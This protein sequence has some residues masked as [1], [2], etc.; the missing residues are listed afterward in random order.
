MR[1]GEPERK[2]NEG[3][4]CAPARRAFVSGAYFGIPS[5]VCHA[6]ASA[7]QPYIY[8]LTGSPRSAEDVVAGSIAV[9]GGSYFFP[10]LIIA[11]VKYRGRATRLAVSGSMQFFVDYPW[12]GVAWNL[13]IYSVLIVRF[14]IKGNPL[15]LCFFIYSPTG[16]I[17]FYKNDI[18][19]HVTLIG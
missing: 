15:G 8:M 18:H 4:L 7:L 14:T 17:I 6:R 10:G 5:C 13:T 11:S 16:I 19:Q 9:I 1:H 2:S 3:P 12:S